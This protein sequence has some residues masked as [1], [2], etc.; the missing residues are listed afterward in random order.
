MCMCTYDCWWV[1]CERTCEP[2]LCLLASKVIIFS[3]MCVLWVW[4][5]RRG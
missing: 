2:L 5:M 3:R 4:R 1:T